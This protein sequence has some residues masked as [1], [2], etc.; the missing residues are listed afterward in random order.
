MATFTFSRIAR[1]DFYDLWAADVANISLDFQHS[2]V[3]PD[4]TEPLA[5]CVLSFAVELIANM[6]DYSQ[7]GIAW[8]GRVDN[9]NFKLWR[10]SSPFIRKVLVNSITSDLE[11]QYPVEV[12]KGE[13][14]LVQA[15]EVDNGGTPT[16]DATVSVMTRPTWANLTQRLIETS[17]SK[18]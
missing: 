10:R 7:D 6:P 4:D 12:R 9:S 13:N 11:L 18:R 8:T 5:L 14:I 16:G 1:W 3:F 15:T 2:F 17:N